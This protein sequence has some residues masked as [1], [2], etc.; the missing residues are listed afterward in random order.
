MEADVVH[1]G[2]VHGLA[3]ICGQAT[4]SM[5]T[6]PPYGVVFIQSPEPMNVLPILQ[7]LNLG[8][9][10][11]AKPFTMVSKELQSC[12]RFAHDQGLRP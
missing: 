10:A 5:V 1:G 7:P 2:H 4:W 12:M 11:R 3:A 6:K 9:H 8:Y